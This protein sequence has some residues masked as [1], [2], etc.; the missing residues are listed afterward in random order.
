MQETSS[1]LDPVWL[2][3]EVEISYFVSF[4]INQNVRNQDCIS[5][6]RSFSPQFKVKILNGGHVMKSDI[7][8]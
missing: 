5:Q 4:N 7:F 6:Q 1:F 3:G 2:I 8:V